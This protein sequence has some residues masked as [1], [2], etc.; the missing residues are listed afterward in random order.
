MDYFAEQEFGSK[1][2]AVSTDYLSVWHSFG[3]VG[4]F[5]FKTIW[6]Q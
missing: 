4:R 3:R 6:E 5:Q 2:C 1:D